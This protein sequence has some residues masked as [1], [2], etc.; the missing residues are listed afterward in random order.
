MGRE[1]RVQGLGKL[2]SLSG[3]EEVCHHERWQPE[4]NIHTTLNFLYR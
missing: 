4:K 3:G 2:G 1:S